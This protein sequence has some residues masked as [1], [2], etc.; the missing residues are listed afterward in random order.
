MDDVKGTTKKNNVNTMC[1]HKS[2]SY[3]KQDEKSKILISPKTS[4]LKTNNEKLQK[5]NMKQG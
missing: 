2:E 4:K 5:K 1:K 3:I